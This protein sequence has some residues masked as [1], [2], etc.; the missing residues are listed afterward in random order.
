ML[1]WLCALFTDPFHV[2]ADSAIRQPP[3]ADPQELRLD[4]GHRAASYATY[5]HTGVRVCLGCY[6]EHLVATLG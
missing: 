4:C 2:P 1:G 5:S 6:H 3:A